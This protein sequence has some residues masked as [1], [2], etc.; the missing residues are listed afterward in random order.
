MCHHTKRMSLFNRRSA[1]VSYFALA[2][3][4]TLSGSA[5]V[6]GERLEQGDLIFD[7]V[8]PPDPAVAATLPRYLEDRGATF[9]DWLAD[10]SM[11]IA[12]RAGDS[13]Q[14]HRLRAPLGM[15]EQLTREPDAVS[16]AAA[17]PYGSDAFIFLKDTGTGAHGLWLQRFDAA[18]ALEAQTPGEPAATMLS[19]DVDGGMALWAHDAR[20]IAYASS[21][22]DGIDVDI[23]V[24]D[25]AA[26][27]S[28][29]RL[30]AGGS[31]SHWRVLDWSPDD[32]RLLLLRHVSAVESGLFVADVD[33][34]TLTALPVKGR[35][36][37]ARFAADGH[38]V[39]FLGDDGG[40]FLRLRYLDTGNGELR[41]ISRD[42][43]HEV[44][45]FDAG[46]DGRYI[47]YAYNDGGFSRL[48]IIDQRRKLE[49]AIADL[50]VGIIETLKFDPGGQR[51]AVTVASALAPR[52]IY[53]VAAGASSTRW[54]QDERGPVDAAQLTAPRL[55]R[56]ATWDRIDDQHRELPVFAY[57]PPTPGPHP[58][59]VLLDTGP[60]LQYRPRY[61]PLLQ[62]L[63]HELN[64]V[65]L[66][67]NLRGA[68]G[69]GRSF[70]ALDDGALREDAI[71]DLGSLLVWIRLQTDLDSARVFVMGQG[72]GGY[73]ALDA[74]VQYGDR[75]RGGIDFGGPSDLVTYLANTAGELRDG[76][77]AEFGDE[78]DVDTRA[79]L[80][81]IA[82][83]NNAAALTHPL[84][85]VHGL[86]DRVVPPTESQQLLARLR[87][88]A[89]PAAYIGARNEG[90]DFTH[91]SNRD[92]F[93]IAAASFLARNVRN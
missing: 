41:D 42:M 27:G 85:I 25:T 40:E 61:D 11:L 7:G 53:V 43:A 36:G 18:A 64:F 28:L 77:R 39:L 75:L 78:R 87:V 10:G 71:R 3:L 59:L 19:D 22:R 15:G 58:V 82:P 79:F 89:V 56:Y 1:G 38:G 17:R 2:L 20:R 29:P 32:K 70:A 35:V 48:A 60:G 26:A 5:V 90:P 93:D 91:K 50:P 34:G 44:E 65:V 52:A 30:I 49:V 72:F 23:Y 73:L 67:P 88:N 4:A 8:P 69:Y 92:A 37:G 45:L 24:Q 84:L 68:S 12:T 16:Q 55:M 66:A 51:L 31:G 83:L 21:R 46:N 62:Y 9:L 86:R 33:S 57:R 80:Q 47:A 76:A 81:R 54:T 6:R 63:L 74:L 13:E 14:V